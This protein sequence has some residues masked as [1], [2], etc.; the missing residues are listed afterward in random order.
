[1]RCFSFEVVAR[2]PGTGARRGRLHTP[3]GVIETPA[4]MPVGTYGAV[5]GIA[6]WD[7][8]QLGAQIVLSNA[9]HLEMRPGS[10]TVRTL[11]SLHRFMGW[12]GPILTDSGGYQVFSLKGHRKVDD[13]GVTFRSPVD[14]SRHR[15]TP[16]SVVGIQQRLGVDIAMP[17]D[18]CAPW[19]ADRRQVE[20]AA[21]RTLLWA[22]RSLDAREEG[23]MALF[24]IV[25]GGFDHALRQRCLEELADQPFDGFSLGG[26]SVGEPREQ[27]MEMV[28][29][30]APQLPQDRPR[31][32]MGVG[33]PADLEYAVSCGVDL[34]DCVLPTRN[35]RNGTLFVD[36]GRIVIKNARYREDPE[37]LEE[38]CECPTCQRFS[39]GYLRHAFQCGEMLASRLM[40]LHNLHHYLRLM[41]S[42]RDA[43]SEGTL[44]ELLA[45]RRRSRQ[46]SASRDAGEGQQA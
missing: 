45:E 27:L 12:D 17:L 37:P 2:D 43:I 14:G 7:L 35:A 22:R 38:G 21:R 39:R 3:H 8:R 41:R 20:E 44:A 15:F 5:K 23:E 46:T 31:Y 9:F 6:P 13:D 36:D 4:F 30:H 26:L 32:L 42:M 16:E 40:T 11:G 19:G 24:G 25:Q 1:M 33:Y 10:D 28:E 18:V 29:Q 34:F